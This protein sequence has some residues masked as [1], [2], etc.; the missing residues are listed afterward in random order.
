VGVISRDGLTGPLRT[1]IPA[2]TP[3]PGA[4]FHEIVLSAERVSRI[5]RIANGPGGCMDGPCVSRHHR[6][7]QEG[8]NN[9]RRA[10]KSEFHHGLLPFAV[11]TRLVFAT[12]NTSSARA[13]NAFRFLFQFAS[14]P[15]Q[16]AVMAPQTQ[17]ATAGISHPSGVVSNPG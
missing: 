9:Q 6:P 11:V 7:S 15:A 4:P 5:P 8:R 12:P 16:I 2:A 3:P 17:V 13:N 14:Q 10:N 1:G